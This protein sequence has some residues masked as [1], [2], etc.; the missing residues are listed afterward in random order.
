M[1]TKER[2]RA[3]LAMIIEAQRDLGMRP[4]VELGIISRDAFEAIE[5]ACDTAQRRATV[6]AALGGG[7][8]SVIEAMSGL[9]DGVAV[10]AALHSRPAT[11]DE[12]AHVAAAGH[13]PVPPPRMAALR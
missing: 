12:T 9:V 2:T 6:Y 3:A 10:H 8:P 7:G 13:D 4:Q 1:T 11:A 5:N